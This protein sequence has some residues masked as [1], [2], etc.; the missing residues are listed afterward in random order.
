MAACHKEKEPENSNS[1]Q[2]MG[3]AKKKTKTKPACSEEST[4]ATSVLDAKVYTKQF[5]ELQQRLFSSQTKGSASTASASKSLA[6]PP[7]RLDNNSN[8]FISSANKGKLSET[9]TN[10]STNEKTKI[11]NVYHN[12]RAENQSLTMNRQGT[13]PLANQKKWFWFKRRSFKLSFLAF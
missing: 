7:N 1:S 4:V 11:S 9:D 12:C 13:P 8:S 2:E 6:P 10:T 3:G 5:P